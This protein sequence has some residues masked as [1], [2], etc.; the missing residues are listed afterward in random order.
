MFKGGYI[1]GVRGR[2][3]ERTYRSI[4]GGVYSGREGQIF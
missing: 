3:W 2:Y 4:K 1:M